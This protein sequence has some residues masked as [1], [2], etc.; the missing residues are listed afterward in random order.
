MNLAKRLMGAAREWNSNLKFG[1]NLYYETVLNH[2][3]AL[4]WFSQTLSAALDTDFDYYA[5]MAYH[6][7]TM[8]E[9]NMEEKEAIDLMAEVAEKA[10]NAVGDPAKV[11]M[12]IQILDWKG[13]EI[14][15]KKEVEQVLTRILEHGNVS[16]AFVP[17]VE[18]FPLH[19]LKGKWSIPK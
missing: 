4:G 16:L 18:Q 7:Q 10:V 1:I 9:L 17:Y 3:N 14:I 6:R 5:V 19:S 15:P 2:S 11:L 13:Y 12:K 8:R